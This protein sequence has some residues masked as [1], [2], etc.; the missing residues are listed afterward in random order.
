[1]IDSLSI[2]AGITAI[3]LFAV[4]GGIRF[5]KISA[6]LGAVI[7]AIVAFVGAAIMEWGDSTGIICVGSLLALA[8][9]FSTLVAGMVLERWV[10]KMQK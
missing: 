9:G 4:I 7:M 3:A 8:F 5:Q 2:S 1:M 10:S 6:R